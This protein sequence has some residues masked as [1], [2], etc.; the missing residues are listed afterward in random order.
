MLQY[1]Y[2]N[3]RDEKLEMRMNSP[4]VAQPTKPI[5]IS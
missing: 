2:I 3:K 4:T 5:L 1:T